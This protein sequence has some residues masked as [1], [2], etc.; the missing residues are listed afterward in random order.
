MQSILVIGDLIKDYNL[1]K[2]PKSVSVYRDDLPVSVINVQAGC[3]WYL[4]EFVKLMHPKN[5]IDVLIPNSKKM[6]VKLF[7]QHELIKSIFQ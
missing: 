3:A 7:H 2:Q 5:S 6:L 1:M 4:A